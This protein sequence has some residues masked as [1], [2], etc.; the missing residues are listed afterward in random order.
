MKILNLNSQKGR[1]PRLYP[2]WFRDGQ[3]RYND[4]VFTYCSEYIL[5]NNMAHNITE[6]RETR[7]FCEH[8]K[9]RE[10][11]IKRNVCYIGH[12]IRD[13][14][15]FY[16]ESKKLIL[17]GNPNDNKLYITPETTF[18]KYLNTIIDFYCHGQ[19]NTFD[20]L[21]FSTL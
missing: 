16:L 9:P 14:R 8:F 7:W 15:F 21:A 12:V 6:N 5:F 17:V 1:K 2:I 4:R 3:W 11:E 13:D 18:A 19:F 20:I 10:H